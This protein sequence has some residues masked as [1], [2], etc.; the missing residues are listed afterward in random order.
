MQPLTHTCK[1]CKRNSL[2]YSGT[3]IQK[4]EI[5]IKRMFQDANVIRLDKDEAKTA[6]Q[7][8]KVLKEFKDNGDILIGTQ[9]IA[10]GHHIESVSTVGVIG[11][12]STLNIPDF[13]SPERTFQ[14]VTQ[15][16]GRAGRGEIPGRVI[17]QTSQPEHYALE[18]ASQHD[19]VTFYNEEVQ[20]REALN[21]PP[22]CKIVNILFS[23]LNNMVLKKHINKA[24]NEFK[25]QINAISHELQLMGPKPA[26]IEQI[27]NYFR[28]NLLIKY[29]K[30][31]E[32]QLKEAIKSLQSRDKNVRVITDFDPRSIL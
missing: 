18:T 15:V 16:A 10:K 20:F 1:K 29:N 11:I 19:Y 3:G 7:V 27:N 5:E 21:Y 31:N 8:H 4:I 17:V 23:S 14:L 25:H 22:Y 32:E 9:M 2:S 30:S 24:F 26:P 13:R 6:K 12:D 28:Y